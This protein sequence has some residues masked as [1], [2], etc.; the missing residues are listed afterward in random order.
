MFVHYDFTRGDGTSISSTPAA[1]TSAGLHG[2]ARPVAN[3]LAG[4]AHG[5]P[6]FRKANDGR[7]GAGG[8]RAPAP[9]NVAYPCSNVA[10]DA[11]TL[12]TQP[13][14]SPTLLNRMALAKRIAPAT[15]P[16]GVAPRCASEAVSR[17]HDRIQRRQSEQ[18]AAALG[19][20]ASDTAVPAPGSGARSP[21]TTRSRDYESG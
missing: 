17:A 12:Q 20:R 15:S 18:W 19:L 7:S 6:A 14:P 16:F 8:Y 5:S 3:H 9:G 21:L 11:P 2:L 4:C 13:T 1:E 10:L